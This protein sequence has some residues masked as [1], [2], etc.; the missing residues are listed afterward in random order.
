MNKDEEIVQ[1]RS[2]HYGP[3]D[4]MMSNIGTVWSA[5]L[6]QHR[7]QNIEPIPNDVVALMLAA[8]KIIRTANNAPY[9]EDNYID[10]RNYLKF[11][12]DFEKSK[13]GL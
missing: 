6:S 10:A 12:E 13:N 5:I 4:V 8:F 1:E 2:K 9:H 7:G 11:A 3:P